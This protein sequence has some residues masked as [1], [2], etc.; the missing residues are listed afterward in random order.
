VQYNGAFILSA[1]IACTLQ[2]FAGLLGC[3]NITRI[4]PLSL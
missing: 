3:G 2:L 1:T 4:S